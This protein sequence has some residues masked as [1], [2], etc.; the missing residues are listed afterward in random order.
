[1]TTDKK[2]YM[3]IMDRKL[4]STVKFKNLHNLLVSI[5]FLCT[6]KGD[7][8]IYRIKGMPYYINLQPKGN[9]AKPYQ[10]KQVRDFL[11]MYGLEVK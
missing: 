2:T 1:M 8:Y 7:H 9:M 4:D 5:G 6:I 3:R 11:N 10:V